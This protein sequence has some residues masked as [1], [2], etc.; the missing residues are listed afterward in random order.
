MP[1]LTSIELKQILFEIYSAG[2][3]AGYAQTDDI[4]TAYNKYFDNLVQELTK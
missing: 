2:F 3:E 4:T 1:E